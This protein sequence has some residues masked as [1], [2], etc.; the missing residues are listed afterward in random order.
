MIFEISIE[1]AVTY[2][3]GLGSILVFLGFAVWAGKYQY[4]SMATPN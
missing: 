3:P 2:G 4:K 1:Y